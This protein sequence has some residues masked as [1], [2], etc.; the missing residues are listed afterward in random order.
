L[1]TLLVSPSQ[2]S[3]SLLVVDLRGVK[4]L[5]SKATGQRPTASA[6]WYMLTSAYTSAL[7]QVVNR[8]LDAIQ[9]QEGLDIVYPTSGPKPSSGGAGAGA[10][11]SA[12]GEADEKAH[13]AAG[14][15]SGV[16][17]PSLGLRFA[18]GT[19]DLAPGA[20]S[21]GPW[22]PVLVVVNRVA[23]TLSSGRPLSL[24]L[25][26]SPVFCRMAVRTTDASRASV[27]AALLSDGTGAASG[28]TAG[29]DGAEGIAR[30]TAVAVSTLRDCLARLSNL[31]HRAP[32]P[33]DG[34]R[35]VAVKDDALRVQREMGALA[36]RLKSSFIPSSLEDKRAVLKF[37]R[38]LLRRYP[39][40]SIVQRCS[41]CA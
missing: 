8:Y 25:T 23:S 9:L 3:T 30:S 26:A 17:G 10:G 31:A 28:T 29:L 27:R 15:S 36:D 2:S 40:L 5:Q 20:V 37:L 41:G 12:G 18:R 22:V 11:S 16:H 38:V 19:V 14:E 34:T 24:N 35:L 4:R 21:P 33:S 7:D 32:V 39:R 6:V 1:L 13:K